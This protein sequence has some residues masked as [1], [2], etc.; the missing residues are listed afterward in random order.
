MTIHGTAADDGGGR[1]GGVEVSV[2]G[3]ASW[4][5]ATG[6]ESWDYIWTPTA[7]GTVTPLARA[8][9]DSGNVTGSGPFTSRDCVGAT[10]PGDGTALGGAGSGVAGTRAGRTGIR[11]KISKRSVRASRR[12]VVRLRV[13]CPKGPACRVH[14][15]LRRKGHTL[16]GRTRTV[17]GG[18]TRTFELK[19]SRSARRT[20]LRKRVLRVTVVASVAHGKTTTV[21]IRLLAPKSAARRP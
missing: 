13:S 21:H 14:V 19:L 15:R 16:A 8:A 1:V 17:P 18:K 9:D 4:H 5:P 20:L 11:V 7:S 2:D 12:G 3:G 10:I 6:R